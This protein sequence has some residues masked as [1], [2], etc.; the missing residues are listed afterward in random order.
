M[1]IRNKLILFMS[2][3]LVVAFV[4]TSLISFMVS[5]NLFHTNLVNETLP[6]I[7]N[8]ILSE[9]QRDLMIP[10]QVSSLMAND[11]FLKDW[12]IAGEKDPGQVVKYL[13]EIREKYGFFTTFFVS[14]QTGRYYYYDGILKVISPEDAHDVWYYGFRDRGKDFELDVDTNEAAA[15]KLTIFINHRLVDYQGRFLGITGVGLN[16]DQIGRILADYEDKFHRMVYMVDF[17]GLIQVHSN[18]DYIEKMSLHQMEGLKAIAREILKPHE[19][20][21]TFEFDRGDKHML[22]T[23]RY[24]PNF[25]WHLLVEHEETRSLS[26][27][28]S[29]M[30][31]NL[32]VGLVS[33]CIIIIIVVLAVNYFQGRLEFMATVDDLTNV[34]NRRQFMKVLKAETTRSIRYNRPLSILMIDVDYFKSINDTYGHPVGDKALV[35]MTETIKKTLRDSDLLGRLGGEEFGAILPEV[36]KDLATG[37]AERIREKVASTPLETDQNLLNMTISI[38]VAT[39]GPESS[40]EDLLRLADQALYQAKETGRNRVCT[41]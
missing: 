18:S 10:I 4:S 5:K 26:I 17:K 34:V 37:V 8:N 7:S 32:G 14:E 22:L 33:T 12:A 11:T 20:A 23:T 3:L 40:D 9:I 31:T 13:K 28:R 27:I 36:D 35:L 24:F 25:N 30:F 41:A 2:S 38:G 21:M 19:D 15:G 39:I 1:S 29:V 6:L 16:M